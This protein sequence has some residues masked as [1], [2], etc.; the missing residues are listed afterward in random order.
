MNH[1]V[2][3]ARKALKTQRQK[4][5][6]QKLNKSDAERK[7]V[8]VSKPIV[9]T[10]VIV[11]HEWEHCFVLSRRSGTARTE[12]A[13][14]HPKIMHVSAPPHAYAGQKYLATVFATLLPV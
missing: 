2:G 3:E 9:P 11:E 14:W 4:I 13:S 6:L 12:K 5:S 7:L 1:V 8:C 10:I